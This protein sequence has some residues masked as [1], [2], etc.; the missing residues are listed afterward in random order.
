ML[1][2][3]DAKRAGGHPAHAVWKADASAYVPGAHDA[4]AVWNTDALA[5]APAGHD[6]QV[7]LFARHRLPSEHVMHGED[8]PTAVWYSPRPHTAQVVALDARA[9]VPAS[10]ASQTSCPS[11][12]ANCPGGHRAQG[13]L[14]CVLTPE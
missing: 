4:H 2:I 5:Y 9:K 3:P 11:I 14:V 6:R 1:P 8:A 13:G 12:E 10:H 7:S